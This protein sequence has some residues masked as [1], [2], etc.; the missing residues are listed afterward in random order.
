[1][2]TTPQSVVELRFGQDGSVISSFLSFRL[3]ETF[4]DPLGVLDFEVAPP[5]A[6]LQEY[7]KRLQ[8][9]ELVACV[10]DGKP[11]ASMMIETVTTTLGPGEMVLIRG[12][13]VTP[14]KNLMESSADDSLSQVLE[15]DSTITD[16]V[17]AAVE[18]Y[19]L[20]TVIATDD[21]GSIRAKTGKGNKASKVQV[22]ALKFSEAR[23]Q[24]NETTY[25]FLARVLTRL[26][27]MLRLD[28]SGE[29]LITRPHYDGDVL[30]TL[31]VPDQAGKAP[32]GVRFFGTV[33][34]RDTN[35]QQ[36]S[37]CEVRGNA[38]D[39]PGR[40][41]G[42][43]PAGSVATEDINSKRPPFRATEALSYKPTFLR[44]ASCRDAERA[45]SMAKLHMGL[46][47]SQAYTI[48]G[49]VPGL[50]STDGVPWTIDTLANV[51]IG[52]LGVNEKMWISE[53]T[54]HV[55]KSGGQHTDL[56]LIPPGN[57]V[58]GNA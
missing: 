14:L 12:E 48:T 47:A 20:S 56:T 11:Q 41:Q 3:R 53:R 43:R 50:V 35:S 52:P 24:P 33:T 6:R 45:E 9:G 10:V 51:Y 37:L 5:P 22:D 23:V 36:P 25:G 44:D 39:K 8:K 18:P 16:L 19:G 46:R 4:T 27:V 2:A 57:L 26:G 34:E 7:R 17:T 42:S 15:S 31:V 28:P 58:L 13:A 1:M 49:R 38:V 55:S 40:T 30:Y 32:P 21:V 29:L 54:F